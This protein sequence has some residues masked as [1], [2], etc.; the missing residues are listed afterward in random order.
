MQLWGT[1]AL[2]SD[3]EKTCLSSTTFCFRFLK[4]MSNKFK[5]LS[6]MSFGFSFKIMPSCYTLS[7]ALKIGTHLM[8]YSIFFIRRRT[9]H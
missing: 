2:T 1:H 5:M 4:K 3:K 7:N 8:I 6:D 9:K